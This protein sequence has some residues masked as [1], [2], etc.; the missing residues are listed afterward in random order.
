MKNTYQLAVLVGMT[1]LALSIIII[2]AYL[3]QY[4]PWKVIIV[5]CGLAYIIG[6]GVK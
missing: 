1:I 2:A 6:H 3:A 4:H 5:I